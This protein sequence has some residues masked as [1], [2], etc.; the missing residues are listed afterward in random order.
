MKNH[1]I[2]PGD[3]IQH[4]VTREIA[5]AKT[6]EKKDGTVAVERSSWQSPRKAS[7]KLDEIYIWPE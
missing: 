1:L 3:I 7:W 5:T 2:F 6:H 4:K